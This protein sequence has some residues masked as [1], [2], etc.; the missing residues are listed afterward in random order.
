MAA[1]PLEILPLDRLD[2][3]A[4]AGMPPA[5]SPAPIAPAPPTATPLRIKERRLVEP[6]GFC[7]LRSNGLFFLRLSRLEF[8]VLF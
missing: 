2:C 6:A 8:H 4:K 3:W 1:S 7:S 5:S